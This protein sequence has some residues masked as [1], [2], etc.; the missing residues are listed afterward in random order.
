MLRD[1]LTELI[2]RISPYMSKLGFVRKAQAFY[3]RRGRNIEVVEFQKSRRSTKAEILFTI[4]LGIC[5]DT[6]FRFFSD[7]REARFPSLN[8]CHWTER[9]GMLAK[10][11]GDKWWTIDERSNLDEL[12]MELVD[13]LTKIAIP[14]MDSLVDDCALEALWHTGQA[15]GLTEFQRLMNLSVLLKAA[16]SKRLGPIIEELRRLGERD[17][18]ITGSIRGHLEMLDRMSPELPDKD[19]AS[20]A[21]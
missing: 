12:T 9:L 13:D 5:S 21:Y 3:A 10:I 20:S 7:G 11:P 16:K 1:A 4:N 17:H 2:V 19:A 18:W 6:L 14:S 15:P 8:E